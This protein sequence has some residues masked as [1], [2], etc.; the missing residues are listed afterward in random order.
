MNLMKKCIID[1]A[2]VYKGKDE[3][4]GEGSKIEKFATACQNQSCRVIKFKEYSC[5]IPSWSSINTL[6]LIK[7]NL[8]L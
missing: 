5:F 8:K 7:S 2:H 3:G 6:E 1:I 4:R